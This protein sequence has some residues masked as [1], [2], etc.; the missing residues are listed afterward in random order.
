MI[1]LKDFSFSF[2]VKDLGV[3]YGGLGNPE[4]AGT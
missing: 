4:A 2:R 1:M 3:G